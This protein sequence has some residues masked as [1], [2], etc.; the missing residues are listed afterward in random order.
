MDKPDI[1]VIYDGCN[2]ITP[3]KNQENLSEENIAKESISIVSYCRVKGVND[4]I[5]SLIR[6]KGQYHTPPP[7]YKWRVCRFQNTG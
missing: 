5:S 3:R 7:S 1:I 2:D 6:R 4:I